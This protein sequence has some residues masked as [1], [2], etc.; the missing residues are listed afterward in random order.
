MKILIAAIGSLGDVFPYI[1][2]AQGLRRRGHA[3]TLGA[4]EA[5]RPYVVAAEVDFAP[6]RPDYIPFAREKTPFC[7]FALHRM[8]RGGPG[9]SAFIQGFTGDIEARYADISPL[10]RRADAMVTHPLHLPGVLAARRI[11]LPWVSTALS[12]MHLL[13]RHDPFEWAGAV[14]MAHH[15]A[16]FPRLGQRLWGWRVPVIRRT[17]ASWFGALE[18]FAMA[19]G[20]RIDGHPL[21]DW[22]F[23]PRGTAALFSTL[24]TSPKPDWPTGTR[25]TGHIPYVGTL[26]PLPDRVN[27]F[28]DAGAPP[29]LFLLGSWSGHESAFFAESAQACKRMGCRGILIAPGRAGADFGGDILVADYLPA[30]LIFPRVAAVVH[31]GGMGTLQFAMRAGKPMLVV[32]HALDQVSNAWQA[33]RVGIARGLRPARYEG[34]TVA[35]ALEALLGDENVARRAVELAARMRAEDGVARACAFMEEALEKRA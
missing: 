17:T 14:G 30:D 10:A 6:L 5:F 8:A 35:A 28:L 15:L 4:A 12:G 19:Q 18:A 3:V 33:C 29:V 9:V 20:V 13:S 32:P 11:G 26:S 2:L 1:G 31:H 34:V 25:I 27:R 23:S 16:R 21:Y 22:P 24:L 7:E